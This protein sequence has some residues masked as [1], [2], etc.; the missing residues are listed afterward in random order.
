MCVCVCV[1]AHSLCMCVNC[2]RPGLNVSQ[3]T[4][5]S[6][7]S[8]ITPRS[9]TSPSVSLRWQQGGMTAK[10]TQHVNEYTHAHNHKSGKS[11]VL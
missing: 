6:L 11:Y 7:D 4:K 10:G 8:L 9:V 5:A 1:C 2:P 3:L